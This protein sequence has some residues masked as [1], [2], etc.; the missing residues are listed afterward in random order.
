MGNH[1]GY[2]KISQCTSS[3]THNTEKKHEKD[4]ADSRS[5][6]RVLAW[7]IV[8]YACRQLAYVVGCV[9]SLRV[10]PYGGFPIRQRELNMVNTRQSKRIRVCKGS[11][12]WV[13]VWVTNRDLCRWHTEEGIECYR[14]ETTNMGMVVLEQHG[15]NHI[16]IVG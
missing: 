9:R 13:K 1:H 2:V 11:G 14:I 4:I 12:K 7:R 5:I 10:F 3:H 15:E 6:N 16:Y 8:L